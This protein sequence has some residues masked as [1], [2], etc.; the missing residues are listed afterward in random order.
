MDKQEI[1]YT[2]RIMIIDDDNDF[3]H[4]LMT[5]FE[6]EGVAALEQA[7]TMAAAFEKITTLIR[8]FLYLMSSCQ[9]GTV[10]ISVRVCANRGLKNRLLC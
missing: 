8:I 6:R 2:A 7:E 1:L 5:Q 10:F 3:R 4:V 9:M